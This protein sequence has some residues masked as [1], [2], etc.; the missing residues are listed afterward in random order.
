MSLYG[1]LRRED[2]LTLIVTLGLKSMGAYFDFIFSLLR[3]FK[4]FPSRDK[5]LF[6]ILY[7]VIMIFVSMI[8]RG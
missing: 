1:S 2:H 6:L 7:I 4:Q 3:L 8:F 5:Y